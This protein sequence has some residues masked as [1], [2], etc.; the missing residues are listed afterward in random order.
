MCFSAEASFIGGAVLTAIGI[1]SVRRNEDPSQRLL[2]AMPL[3]FGVQQLSEGVVWL[4]LADSGQSLLLKVSAYIFLIAA[5]LIWPTF[6]PLAVRLQEK[7]LNRKPILNILLALGL[8]TSLAYL[9]G[10]LIFPLQV[11]AISHHV[12]YQAPGAPLILMRL[13]YFT[14]LG[15][16]ILPLFVTGNRKIYLLG[17]VILLSYGTAAI[18]Y[19]EYLLSVW[20]FFAALTSIVVWW[21][22]GKAKST[23]PAPVHP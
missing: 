6:V 1:A 17:I 18:L 21:I 3:V 11:Q 8:L 16:T 10:M 23:V 19:T 13:A 14:Y 7:Q 9:A 22:V 15:A 5:L 4:G 2:S 12:V 20:C